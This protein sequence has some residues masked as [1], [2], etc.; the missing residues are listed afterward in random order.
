MDEIKKRLA[1]I[2]IKIPQIILPSKMVDLKKWAVIACDQFTQDAG[3]WEKVAAFTEN[4]PSTFNL[5]YP[6]IYLN[7]KD[8]S[9]RIKRIHETMC[10]Y[11]DTIF[12]ENAILNPPRQA[13]AFIE[14]VTQHG[15]RRGVV[16]AIDLEA[17]DWK[18]DSQSII[19]ATEGTLPERLPPRMEIR[20]GA[21]L[22]LPHILLLINDTENILMPLLEKLLVKAPVIYD[23]P[24]MLDGESVRCRLLYRKNDWA[25]IQDVFEHLA[26]TS[27]NRFHIEN[28]F[29]FAV[30]D[31]NHSLAAAKAVWDEY[32]AAHADDENINN[33]PARYALVE[34]V[35]LYDTA[36][37]FEPI[38][39]IVFNADAEKIL[40]ILSA[41]PG[42]SSREVGGK[43][44]LKN[45]VADN[46]A[47]SRC[48]IVSGEQAILVKYSG[49]KSPT[50]D[51]D[52]LL[53]S[54][55]L[56]YIHGE[57]EL[58]R[59]ASKQ[60]GGVAAAGILLPPF[61]KKGLFESIASSGP[62]PRK[63][64]SMGDAGEKR[65]YLEC[66]QLFTVP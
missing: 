62:L 50:A 14:R 33:H 47:E 59:L 12:T 31:G 46:A 58:F 36:I 54:L 25:L 61:S 9:E 24:L 3:Y 32:K 55:E 44:Q 19:R 21:C 49:G 28:P 2:G 40:G 8:R 53:E 64:F 1:A 17:Y 51:I 16:L 5:I 65:F 43:E 63:S 48:G 23:T 22:E 39:R 10:L 18:A 42:F 26:R 66:R 4:A 13:G 29:L 52:P 57:D 41:L 60:D 35:N 34:V 20:R 7:Q 38:H 56:D 27:F 30:G 11:N 37:V 15:I 6:E 45:M